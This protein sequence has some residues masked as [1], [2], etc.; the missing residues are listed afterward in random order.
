L[1][2]HSTL[3]K[4]LAFRRARE[5]EAFHTPQNLAVA[6]SVEAGELLEHFQ[7][8]LPSDSAL[9]APRV[10]RIAEEIADVA[11][12]LSYLAHDL[13]IDIDDA[14]ERKL[15][16]NAERYPIDRSRGSAKKYTEL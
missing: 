13:G 16:V 4:V 15:V 14:V 6:V 12:L 5:W 2:S 11:I 9:P 1:L 3:Q 8:M 7:W 10:A